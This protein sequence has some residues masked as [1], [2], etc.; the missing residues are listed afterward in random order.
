[1]A[2][3]SDVLIANLALS[4]IGEPSIN[5]LTED[6]D[7]ARAVNL[8]FDHIRQV[9]LRAGNWNFAR[10]RSALA[11]A[12]DTPAFEFDKKY[13]LPNDWVRTIK[14]NDFEDDYEQEGEFI[15]TDSSTANLKYIRDVTDPTKQDPLFREAFASRLAMEL[16]E[17]IPQDSELKN[18]LR[19]EFKDN[20][21]EARSA[22]AM[23]NLPE[24]LI[25]DEWLDARLEPEDKFRPIEDV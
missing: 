17:I 10:A 8:V 12:T 21:Q 25:A 3:I 19:Q 20:M 24:E 14:F 15:L 4:K 2:T 5:S 16:A 13:K 22:D 6:N 7:A 23:E 11:E 1:M 9:V 18:E